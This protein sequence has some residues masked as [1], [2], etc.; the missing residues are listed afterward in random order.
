MTEEGFYSFSS[1]N[2]RELT[3]DDHEK[4]AKQTNISDF[5]QKKLEIEAR[6]NWDK[7]Y[8]RNKNNFFKDRNWSAEDLKI[9]CPDI[10]FE[11]EISYLEAGCGVGNML[12][13]LVAEIPKL[14]LFAFDFSDNA[15]RL[16]EERAKELKLP[17][18][19]S[20]VDLSIPSVSSPFDEQV[21]L[22]TLIFVLSAIHP[23][24]MQIAAENMRN[25]VKIGGS[26]VVRDYGINDHAMIR[27]GREARISDRFYVRQDGTRAYY[28]DLDELTG[29]FENSGFRCVR[30]E[31]LHRMTINHQKNLKAPRIFVQAR[32][33]REK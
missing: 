16:L 8:N 22:A 31:Y 3:E 24:K 18:T 33:I 26:V 12:F 14:K 29:F 17:V 4:L 6:K 30:K 23:D 1:Q 27:F 5:K 15:V 9:I 25:L 2:S 13:P 10:D 19:T 11:Q 20:V 32:F 21:D 7:F 28:F